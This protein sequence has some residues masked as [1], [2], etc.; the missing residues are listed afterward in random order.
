M[1][2]FLSNGYLVGCAIT[3][4]YFCFVAVYGWP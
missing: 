2:K 1:K 3:I 4:L